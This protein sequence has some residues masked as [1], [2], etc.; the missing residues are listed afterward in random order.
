MAV[1][2]GRTVGLEGARSYLNAVLKGRTH[3]L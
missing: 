2:E 1:L 3:E